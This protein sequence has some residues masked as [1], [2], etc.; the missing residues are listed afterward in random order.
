MGKTDVF[1]SYAHDLKSVVDRICAE[2]ENEGIRCWYAPR[3]V[4]GDYAT[5]IVEAID[6]TK[7]FVVLLNNESSKSPHVL[8]EVEMAYKRIIEKEGELTILPLKLDDR[9]L[10]K[11]MEYYVKRMHWIDAS[12][13][14]VENAVKELKSKIKAI[15]KPCRGEMHLKPKR[16]SNK[17][18]DES[19]V[20]EKRRLKK[21]LKISENFDKSVFD[22]IISESDSLRVLD[23]G[24]NCGDFI[25]SRFGERN[26]LEFILGLDCN[27]EV[28]ARADKQY[29][30]E[31][32]KFEQCDL[33]GEDFEEKL[34]ELV[35]KYGIS[36]FNVVNISM[37]I[38]HLQDPL[39]MLR[40]VRKSMKKG[41]KI[42]IKDI[43]DGFNVAYP[44]EGELFS[45]AVKICQE[46]KLGGYRYSGRQIYE[47]LHKSGFK[48]I[49]LLK[50]GINTV[51]MD[52]DERLALFDIYFS[53]IRNDFLQLSE[54]YP[55]NTVY[56]ENAKWV[57][58]NYEKLEDAFLGDNFFFSLGFMLF[59]A[60]K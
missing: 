1:L 60:E 11:A 59:S 45:H 26:N 15:L 52:Y 23:L 10:S 57:T 22:D 35:L 7:V 40:I 53:F 19:D 8:N 18:Y 46:N 29:A 38:L 49:K 30:N 47:L 42:I 2:L 41:A 14:G 55:E 58:E 50:C 31:K 37:L 28:I 51:G 54:L 39:K 48:N 12:T 13:Q 5:S 25:I 43:D 20:I 21:Q 17:Y 33:E 6:E 34:G 3:D 36:D 32:I 24:C 27:S 44:D 56:N 4:V 9:D 16:E